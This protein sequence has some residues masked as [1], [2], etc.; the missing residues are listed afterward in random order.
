MSRVTYKC[1]TFVD[2]AFITR[3]QLESFCERD[4]NIK[5]YYDLEQLRVISQ[6]VQPLDYSLNAYEILRK[7]LKNELFKQGL[8]EISKSSSK[9]AAQYLREHQQKQKRRMIFK[10]IVLKRIL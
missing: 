4:P 3:I 10:N 5:R 2:I 7:Q 9:M 8:S 6:D 1:E